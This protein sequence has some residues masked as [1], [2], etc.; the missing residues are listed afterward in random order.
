VKRAKHEKLTELLT[1][2]FWSGDNCNRSVTDPERMVSVIAAIQQL[3][4]SQPRNEDC[5]GCLEWAADWLDIRLVE[6]AE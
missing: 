2:A 3:L 4:R 5:D 1:D 6:D